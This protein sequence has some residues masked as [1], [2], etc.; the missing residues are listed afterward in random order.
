M[1]EDVT[2]LTPGQPPMRG[3]DMFVDGLQLAFRQIRIE[4]VSEVQ[5]VQVSGDMAYCWN[6]L[7]VTVTPK[8]GGA[9]THRVGYSL[10]ILRKQ[11]DGQWVV[12]RDANLL[13]TVDDD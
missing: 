7:T 6:H 1:A 4:P 2:F 10:T 13:A 9:P 11:P 5:E 12:A 8:K 3:R